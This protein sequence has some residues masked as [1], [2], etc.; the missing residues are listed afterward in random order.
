LVVGVGIPGPV[1]LERPGRLAGSG[2]AQVEGN[3]AILVLEFLHRVERRI[4]AINA[5]YAR[6]Q[7]AAGDQQ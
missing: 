2:V 7:S 4:A 5:R 6:I 3:A 1:D